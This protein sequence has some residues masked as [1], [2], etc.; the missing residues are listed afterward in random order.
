M[1]IAV[2]DCC[3]KVFIFLQCAAQGGSVMKGRRE[4]DVFF[5]FGLVGWVAGWVTG[6]SMK[7]QSHSPWMDAL[8]GLL[9]G[10]LAGY[11]M[12]PLVAANN[13]GLLVGVLAATAGG[14]LLTWAVHRV[15]DRFRHTTH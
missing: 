6:K 9:G 5:W 12:H 11:P 7:C 4:M 14:V 1:R 2:D 8:I 3:D 13:W 10:L 15:L